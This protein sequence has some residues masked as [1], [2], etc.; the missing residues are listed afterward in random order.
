MFH[1]HKHKHK[2]KHEQPTTT[3]TNK[4]Q[5]TTTNNNQQ[6]QQQQQFCECIAPSAASMRSSPKRT[7][8][9]R[10]HDDRRNE[11]DG[12]RVLYGRHHIA[13]AT[14]GPPEGK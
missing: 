13:A 1:T 3:N 9:S 4:H 14:Q 5:Q 10:T 7:K 2:H 11:L 8:R 6:Q 12:I